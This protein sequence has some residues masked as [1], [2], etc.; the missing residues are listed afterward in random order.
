MLETLIRPPPRLATPFVRLDNELR[1][2]V[3]RLNAGSRSTAVD[4]NYLPLTRI[5]S[6]MQDGERA[7]SRVPDIA[8]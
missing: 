1:R 7:G 8:R 2:Y 6:R 3:V 5:R 4:S